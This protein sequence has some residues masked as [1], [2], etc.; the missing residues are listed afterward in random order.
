MAE[1]RTWP[2]LIIAAP[3]TGSP[4]EIADRVMLALDDWRVA[5]IEDLAELPLPPGG[6]WDPTY[7]PVPDPPPAPVRWRVFFEDQAERDAARAALAR[8]IPELTLTADNVADEDW[9]AR[10][11]RALTAVHA[12]DVI[13]APPWDV[14]VAPPDKT[15]VVIRPSMGFGTGHHATT[16]LCLKAI[17][18]IDLRDRAVLDIGTGS[19]VLAMAAAL[20]GARSAHGVDVDADAIAS[21]CD[22]AVLNT[23][24]RAPSFEVA[25][26]RAKDG[27]S[28]D[29]VIA[30]LTGGMLVSAA[31]KLRALVAP[32]G[33][34]IVSGFDTS[35]E[36]AVRAALGPA[37]RERREVEE[38]WVCLVLE[39]E[40]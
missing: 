12:G 20:R 3:D 31:A 28:G 38:T 5:A 11:Q 4:T 33:T 17:S 18:R 32:R 37:S 39:L 40:G 1:P 15:L 6:L 23:F 14:P 26:F 36:D 8:L 25:D 10:S 24:E 27:L 30:N 21:A 2:A 22:S 13:V 34:L 35:E 29:I 7:P 16:R 19:G 9:A